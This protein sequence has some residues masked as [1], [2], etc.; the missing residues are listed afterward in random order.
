MIFKN[1]YILDNNSSDLFKNWKL[2][3]W[4][5]SYI[6][7]I[8]IF[9]SISLPST[10]VWAE[11]SINVKFILAKTQK[12]REREKKYRY[13]NNLL[14]VSFLFVVSPSSET[15]TYIYTFLYLCMNSKKSFPPTPPHTHS[16]VPDNSWS[17]PLMYQRFYLTNQSKWLCTICFFAPYGLCVY[18]SHTQYNTYKDKI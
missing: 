18:L 9:L 6:I 13:R 2:S 15:N 12:G 5:S 8:Y 3:Q 4:L 14:F 16:S 17:V 1:S 7:Y 11:V 10:D